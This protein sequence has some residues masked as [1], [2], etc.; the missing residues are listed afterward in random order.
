MGVGLTFLSGESTGDMQCV[1]I[2][3]I[4]DTIV[5]DDETF[6]VSLISTDL[7]VNITVSDAT[8]TINP[9]NDSTCVIHTLVF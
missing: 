8:V 2:S 4:D 5:E 1:N 9:D 7:A 3:I 6:S